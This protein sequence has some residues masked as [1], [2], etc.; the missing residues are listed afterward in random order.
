VNTGSSEWDVLERAD[1]GLQWM[2][3][4]VP[5]ASAGSRLVNQSVLFFELLRSPSQNRITA[6]LAVATKQNILLYE[7]V[8]GERAFR[9][10]KVGVA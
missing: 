10:V 1:N 6:R 3:D 2:T 8:R 7:T 5:L 9:F 4:Y